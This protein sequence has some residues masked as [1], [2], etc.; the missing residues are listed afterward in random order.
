[1]MTGGAWLGSTVLGL[2]GESR[3]VKTI[4]LCFTT[5]LHGHI[6]PT[7]TY[8]D[9]GD[10]GG[11][12]R[13]AS[14]IREWR[15]Q[16]PDS[17]LVD[18]GDVYQGTAV[19]LET[20][21]VV[22]IDLFNRLGYDAW[23]I[24]NHDLDWGRGVIEGALDRSTP[25]VLTGNLSADG[26]SGD[27]APGPWRKVKPW[28]I[29][30]VGG[31]RIG[32]VGVTTPGMPFWLAPETLDGV[33]VSDPTASLKQSV[34]ELRAQKVDAVVALGHMGWRFEDD[35][36][37]PIREMLK[38]V[39]EVDVYL[40]GHSHRDEPSFRVGDVLC[41]QANYFGIHCGRVDLAFDLETHKL[42]NKRAFTVLMDSRFALD[43]AVMETAQPELKESAEHL[44]REVCE[45]TSPL[46]ETGKRSLV[47][48]L[49]MAFSDALTKAGKPIDAVFHGSFGTGEIEP[50]MKTVADCW[51]WLP[52]ENLLVT[53]QLTP[54]EIL[55]VVA[56]GEFRSDRAL[57]PLEVQRGSDRKPVAILH[58]GQPLD[59]SRRYGIAMNSYDAQSGG[60]SL[61][62][63]LE[64]LERPESKRE[65]TSIAAR[66]A[67]IDFLLEKKTI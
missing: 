28:L 59:P 35:F 26:R 31:F 55:E 66:E 46:P 44:A 7:Q 3:R 27:D 33:G 16:N 12:A 32:L 60:R 14:Q 64:I 9:I 15:R 38:A 61:M 37:N 29:K 49:C 8:D 47:T 24:G 65:M 34:A 48:V 58:E 19:G 2:A 4:S 50:G 10:V 53:A 41:S 54:A 67:L 17:L 30:E 6:E 57:W 36:A 22:M 63:T 5:D 43:P 51:E 45:V 42:V 13:C 56:E 25:A 52:Y 40:A 23:V 1:M 20:D 18:I 11:L 39:P 21:G 62:R